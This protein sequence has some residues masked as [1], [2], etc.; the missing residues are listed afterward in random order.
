MALTILAATNLG[1]CPA[2]AGGDDEEGW[3]FITAVKRM[4]NG[5]GPTLSEVHEYR[6]AVRKQHAEYIDEEFKK[7]ENNGDIGWKKHYFKDTGLLREEI[8]THEWRCV[9][10]K[11]IW[12]YVKYPVTVVAGTVGCRIIYNQTGIDLSPYFNST[13][14]LS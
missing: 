12:N 3:A 10:L 7:Q 13:I 1:T 5:R 6:A 8:E 9:G 4:F 11:T 2:N 14:P